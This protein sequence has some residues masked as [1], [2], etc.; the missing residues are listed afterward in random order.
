[1]RQ[2]QKQVFVRPALDGDG[3]AVDIYVGRGR[4]K[5]TE[6]FHER[7]TEK[8][9]MRMT[10]AEAQKRAREIRNGARFGH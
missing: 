3:W 1:M 10:K 2:T 6:Y 5:A 7:G 9:G 4:W 8:F